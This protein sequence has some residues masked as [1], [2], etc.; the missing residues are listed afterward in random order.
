MDAK[1]IRK[2]NVKTYPRR[3]PEKRSRKKRTSSAIH[4]ILAGSFLVMT[5]VF[6]VYAGIQ[7]K[8]VFFL[9]Q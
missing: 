2:A 3:Y 4:A 1:K 7:Y 6:Y 9:I 5:G 8:Y